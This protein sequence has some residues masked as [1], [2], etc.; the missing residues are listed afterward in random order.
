MPIASMESVMTS[1]RGLYVCITDSSRVLY[2]E[3][4]NTKLLSLANHSH[5][6]MTKK[7]PSM[8][9]HASLVRHISFHIWSKNHTMLG[10]G[11][12]TKLKSPFGLPKKTNLYI[13]Q[14]EPSALDTF[15]RTCTE[16]RTWQKH[17]AQYDV[18]WRFKILAL[19][20]NA[21][22]LDSMSSLCVH[23]IRRHFGQT[24]PECHMPI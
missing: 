1:K 5:W 3:S 18:P 12:F 6:P 13:F 14:F 16:V 17:Y 24:D 21:A 7:R 20:E 10:K 8:Q 11:T 22:H 2:L 19:S 15:Y 4:S 9:W 23:A